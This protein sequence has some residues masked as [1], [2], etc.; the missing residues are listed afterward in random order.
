MSHVLYEEDHLP[1]P[2]PL[3]APELPLPL[4]GTVAD[5]QG[6]H[7]STDGDN[8]VGRAENGKLCSLSSVSTILMAS[9]G[10]RYQSVCTMR[11]CCPAVVMI[12]LLFDIDASRPIL[13]HLILLSMTIAVIVTGL[14]ASSR[15]LLGVVQSSAHIVLTTA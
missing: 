4:A 14:P 9:S 13:S 8:L 6:L 11:C 10:H 12:C 15:D 5:H 3:T 1:E 2:D 7:L